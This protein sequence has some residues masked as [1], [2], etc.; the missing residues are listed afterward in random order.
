MRLINE[1]YHAL[2]RS[3][4]ALRRFG[5]T[6]GGAFCSL[7]GLFLWRARAGGS[8]QLILGILLILAAAFQPRVLRAVHRGWMTLALMLG[9]V[10]TRIILTVVFFVV[11]TP[12]G[13]LQRLFGKRAVEVAFRT[14]AESY[15]EARPR[16][17]PTA[18]DYEKQF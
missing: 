14:G 16:Q 10:M 12:I 18:A 15:W 7:G 9:F 1:E 4:R 17:Q 2:D 8:A 3:P 11:L 6:I 13:L 5:F